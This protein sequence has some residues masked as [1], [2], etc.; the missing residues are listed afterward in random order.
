MNL[1]INKLI[2]F[3][4][5]GE[6]ELLNTGFSTGSENM[7]FD[8]ERTN[9][10]AAG[11][12]QPM[13]RLYG[14][15]P[16]SVSLGANQ[17]ENEIDPEACSRLGFDI[18]RRPTGGRAV[19]HAN[20]LTYSVVTPLPEGRTV[21][22]VYR[23]IHIILLEAFQSIGCSGLDF[24]KSQP[25]FRQLYKENEMSVSCFASSARYEISLD[26]R[27][28]VG[29]AQRLFGKALLQHGSILLGDGFEQLA[30]TA[31][32]STPEKRERLM[33]FMKSHSATL[34]E[35]AGRNISFDEAANAVMKCVEATKAT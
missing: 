13:F 26:G 14:W 21:H 12:A 4:P 9:A 19:L 22:D 5:N 1:M 15:N 28:I 30:L 35:A 18:V 27:K 29:S 25:D 6:F 7:R 3:F 23:D 32:V 31:R 20:E 34:S 2:D 8:M 16:W 24:Q 10:V 11:T 17:D 33:E